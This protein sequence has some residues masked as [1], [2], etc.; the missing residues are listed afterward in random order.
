MYK[1]Y[2]LWHVSQLSCLIPLFSAVVLQSQ[3]ETVCS[4][5]PADMIKHKQT[6]WRKSGLSQTSRG[7]N[8]ARRWWPGKYCTLLLLRD[9]SLFQW[10]WQVNRRLKLLQL[11]CG[12]DEHQWNSVL[13][14]P[15]GSPVK[16]HHVDMNLSGLVRLRKQQFCIHASV[17]IGNSVHC[18]HLKWNQLK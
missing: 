14:P 2:P 9:Q 12:I 1:P 5:I 8:R 7:S 3:I 18:I 17:N 13:S 6:C 15:P 10:D 11:K 4:D 16:W